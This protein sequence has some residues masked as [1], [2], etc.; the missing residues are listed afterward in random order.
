MRQ[1][2]Y[3]WWIAY[4]PKNALDPTSWLE[5]GGGSCE[6]VRLARFPMSMEVRL[7]SWQRPSLFGRLLYWPF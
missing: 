3:A 5:F 4:G 7:M 1:T 6:N 2:P